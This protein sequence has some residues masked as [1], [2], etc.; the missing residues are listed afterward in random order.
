MTSILPAGTTAGRTPVELADLTTLRVGG[1]VRLLL[2]ADTTEEFI[3]ALRETD[4]KKQPLLVLGGGSN[5]I[6][7]DE[8]CDLVVIR[9]RYTHVQTREHHDGTTHVTASAGMPWDEFVH[10]TLS[11]GFSGLEALSGIP[12]TVG[13]AP[14]QNIGAYGYEVSDNLVSIRAW[15]RIL[16][17]EVDIAAKDLGL[18]YRS[19]MMKRAC[20]RKN[21]EEYSWGPTSRWVVTSAT[22]ALTRSDLSSPIRYAELAR[23]IGTENGERT[24][25]KDLRNAVLHVRQNKGM[26]LDPFD[27]DTWSAG[28][29][30]TN[31]LL[32]PQE[33]ETLLP[34]DAPCFP[35][36]GEDAGYVKTSAAWLIQHSG[37]FK[38]WAPQEICDADGKPRASLSTKH[39]LALTNRGHATAADLEFL[40]R[41]VRTTVQE[42]WGITLQPEPV[43]V[44]IRW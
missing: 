13:A 26:V 2:E 17:K 25:A 21:H 10:W 37:M 6:A 42:H 27:H 39:V 38:G 15:D 32:T 8:P 34:P 1:P 22:F 7:S 30:F 40:A 3:E 11:E 36:R 44:G 29:F 24:R 35:G 43:A 31:P 41:S 14:V 5:L 23:H 28:S 16:S 33:A 12:G 19:S 4:E 18:R 9:N 20:E